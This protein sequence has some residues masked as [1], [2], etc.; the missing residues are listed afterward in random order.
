[1]P[2]I[3]IYTN[4]MFFVLSCV[5]WSDHWVL[6][7]WWKRRWWVGQMQS[8]DRWPITVTQPVTAGSETSSRFSNSGRHDIGMGASR[9]ACVW[10]PASETSLPRHDDVSICSEW[11][12]QPRFLP[13]PELRCILYH[14]DARSLAAADAPLDPLQSQVASSSPAQMDAGNSHVSFS[15]G[16]TQRAFR[17]ALLLELYTP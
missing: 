1:M 3:Y 11:R 7:S 5:E 12:L 15:R 16:H 17:H 10:G 2:Y 8:P 6:L 14:S 9:C 13:D 4:T